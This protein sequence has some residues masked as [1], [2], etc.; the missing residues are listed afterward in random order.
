MARREDFVGSS[1][2]VMQ[3]LHWIRSHGFKPVVL[4]HRSKAAINRNYVDTTYVP[5]DD[6]MWHNN[7]Y[8]VGVVTGP[9]QSG[10]IDL[11]LDCLEAVFFANVFFPTTNA[12]FGRKSKPSSHF[13]YLISDSVFKWTRF[14]DPKS[15][16]TILELRGDGGCQ[17]VMPGSLHEDTGELIWWSETLRSEPH[18][19]TADELMWCAR[20]TAIAVL[21]AR[22]LW[23]EGSRNEYNKHLCG[24]MFNYEWP[25]DQAEQL[26]QAVMD[27]QGD[28]DNTRI[29]TLRNTYNRGAT[30]DKITG[31]GRLIEQSQEEKV[32]RQIQRWMGSEAT[33]ALLEY[34]DRFAVITS[35]KFRIARTDVK[36][37]DIIDFQ[38]AED[39]TRAYAT[40]YAMDDEGKRVSRAKLWLAD[41]RRR[42]Y[43]YVDFLPGVEDTGD[44]LNL[45]TGWAMSPDRHASC[46]AWLELLQ[47]VI[48]GNDDTL[49]DWV[50]HWFASIV[51]Q[52]ME[53]SLTALV[54]VGPEGAGKSLLLSYFGDLL[55]SYYI[56]VTNDEQIHGKF[57][58][59]TAQCLL[60][61]SEEA[62]WAGDK[63]HAAVIRSLITDEFRMLEQKGI[64]AV[65]I[66]NFSRLILTSNE[67]HAAPVR[68]GDRRYTIINMGDRKISRKLIDAVLKERKNGGPA[69]LLHY[70]QTMQFNPELARTNIKNKALAELKRMGGTPVESWW[71]DTLKSGELLPEKLAWAQDPEKEPWPIIVSAKA[72][73]RSM[74]HHIK[75]RNVRSAIPTEM[76]MSIR[77]KQMTQH[78]FK[79]HAYLRYDDPLHDDCPP[80]FKYLGER[81]Y[82]IVDMPSLE[83]CRL[84]FNKYDGQEYDWP[85]EDEKSANVVK[86]KKP[87]DEF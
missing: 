26:V 84:A 9:A 25:L 69:A 16:D 45:W 76:E 57:N 5:P 49:F 3:T 70:L 22:H 79:P 42:N 36:P 47:M 68:P 14:V 40:D 83:K 87:G 30:G 19:T 23:N 72:L 41:P 58:K 17:T 63:R 85:G 7:K 46:E 1:D 39:F 38:L 67:Q 61:H 77:L 10:P 29:K 59:H 65:R 8:G 12:K 74:M 18:A 6:A 34:N 64:D 82:S 32:V 80:D 24:M 55:G 52:P 62:L 4:H 27:F 31:A 37:G 35:G 71:F 21:I 53:K 81:Q 73:H 43:R 75:Q 28:K 20:K 60:L 54:L 48:C 33:T 13:L 50:L 78:K 2:Q 86:F 15:N 44:T 56:P 11:D 66:R 51:R